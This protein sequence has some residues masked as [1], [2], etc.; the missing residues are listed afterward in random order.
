MAEP[1]GRTFC[2]GPHMIP[3]KVYGWLEMKKCIKHF[4]FFNISEKNR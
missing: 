1:I 2:V 4:L 3:G